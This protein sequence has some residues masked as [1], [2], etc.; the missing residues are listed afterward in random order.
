MARPKPT[1]P[2]RR[3]FLGRVAAAVGVV[4][5]GGPSVAASAQTTTSEAP[6]R[7]R[8]PVGY[9]VPELREGAEHAVAIQTVMDRVAD[10]GGGVVI[11]PAAELV[12]DRTLRVPSHVTL[13]G[14]GVPGT[15]LVAAEDL[16]DPL[17][18][19][20]AGAEGVALESLVLDAGGRAA[21]GVRFDGPATY[22]IGRRVRVHGT[23][24]EGVVLAE[25]P[26]RYLSFEQLAIHDARSDAFRLATAE[27][28]SVFL[29]EISIG[30]F[31]R[32]SERSAGLRL[33]GRCHVS[34]I[35]IDPVGEGQVGVL[36]AEGSDGST[37]TNYY[38][39]SE[40]GIAHEAEG[41]VAV[42]VGQGAVE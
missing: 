36:F 22:C 42:A 8:P 18:V 37:L 26:Y 20:A 29:S 12:L 14:I 39:R 41:S 7:G 9:H 17:V 31:G 16:R 10:Q 21:N 35:S 19:V 1:V 13:R 32:G 4:G 3:R 2:G 28:T 38:V 33:G 11:L 24:G 30:A 15:L 6:D 23:T 5:L 25:G 27:C 40:G 34:Q